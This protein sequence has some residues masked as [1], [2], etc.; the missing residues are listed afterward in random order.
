MNTDTAK[1]LYMAPD[2][3]DFSQICEKE[4]F[5]YWSLNQFLVDIS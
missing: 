5:K 1:L 2:L 3:G 4:I